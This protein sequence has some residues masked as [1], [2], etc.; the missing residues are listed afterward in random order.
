ME[1]NTEKGLCYKGHKDEGDTD[2]TVREVGVQQI[3]KSVRSQNTRSK[4]YVMRKEPT[5]Y[6]EFPV[7]NRKNP[8]G[9]IQRA[10]KDAYT[11][12]HWK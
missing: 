12:W 9:G 1:V 11:G 10:G 2:L 4:I 6:E 8:L 7:K 5:E 3:E